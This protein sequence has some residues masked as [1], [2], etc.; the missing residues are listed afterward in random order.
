MEDGER[1]RLSSFSV[2]STQKKDQTSQISPTNHTRAQSYLLKPRVLR[3]HV[4]RH[5]CAY[6]AG[7]N[8]YYFN[9]LQ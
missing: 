8:D 2:W 3:L 1:R 6:A 5:Y 7:S 9:I 4:V